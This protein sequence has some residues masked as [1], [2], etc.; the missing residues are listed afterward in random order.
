M[1][2]DWKKKREKG[3]LG[4]NEWFPQELDYMPLSPEVPLWC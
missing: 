4:R 2:D 1:A 3:S